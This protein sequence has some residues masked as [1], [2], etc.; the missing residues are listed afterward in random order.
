MIV[1]LEMSNMRGIQVKIES[2]NFSFFFSNKDAVKHSMRAKICFD[3][4]K[5]KASTSSNLK[6]CDD[7]EFEKNT[8]AGNISQSQINDVIS[9]FK[10]YASIFTAAWES[11]IEMDVLEDY[12]KGRIMLQTVVAEMEIDDNLKQK[13]I[14]K[15][16]DIETFEEFIINNNIFKIIR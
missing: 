10:K 14:F 4:Q 12:L 9:F 3:K 2:I 7:W 5:L 6:L 8:D 11:I 1:L 15:N 13:F 16:N